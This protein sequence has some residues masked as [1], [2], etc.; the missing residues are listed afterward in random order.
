MEVKRLN[1]GIN[2]QDIP[3]H[4]L[5][6]WGDV[7]RLRDGVNGR[8]PDGSE[9]QLIARVYPEN[10]VTELTV[11]HIRL[12]KMVIDRLSIKG[13][14]EDGGRKFTAIRDIFDSN[15]DSRGTVELECDETLHTLGVVE[16]TLLGR[17]RPAFE[18]PLP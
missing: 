10:T 3:R 8:Q 14:A 12:G 4:F 6:L 18:D 11:T 1:D 7:A 15:I 5:N 16:T 2:Q 9:I 17:G 13:T